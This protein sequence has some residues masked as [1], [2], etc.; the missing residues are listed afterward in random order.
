M[1]SLQGIL[2]VTT[3]FVALA[4]ILAGCAQAPLGPTV[5]ALQGPR[6]SFADFQ[7][8][9]SY[10][11]T[12]AQSQ[13]GGAVNQ[14]N[15]QQAIA[16]VGNMVL[17]AAV[18]ALTGSG[19]SYGAG[20]GLQTGAQAGADGAAANSATLQQRYDNS[21]A[22]C[23]V[24]K[25]EIVPGVAPAVADYGTPSRSNFDPL[26]RS[27]Q[28][29]LVRTGYLSGGVDG[30]YGP[31]TRQAILSFERSNGLSADASASQGLLER[32][33]SAPSGSSGS[34][35][36][37]GSLVQPVTGPRGGAQPGLVQPISAPAPAVA[38]GGPLPGGS[39]LVA[40]VTGGAK[41]P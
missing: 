39:G 35:A 3:P 38:P 16:T 27:I 1:R 8:D 13:L 17:G 4:A 23:M 32:L 34:I 11:M 12:F 10:C 7:Q 19:A 2:K 37:V 6:K 28:A 26:V 15:Q 24:A 18:G 5:Q 31:M 30:S 40:P 36:A 14:A 41:S 20:Q 22:Q 9:N 21:F 29:E 25:G 33:R